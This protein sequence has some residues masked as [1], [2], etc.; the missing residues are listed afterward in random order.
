[1]A[2]LREEKLR[3]ISEAFTYPS[4]MTTGNI[5]GKIQPSKDKA[6]Q[7]SVMKVRANLPISP[8]DFYAALKQLAEAYRLVPSVTFLLD[9]RNVMVRN[10]SCPHTNASSHFKLQPSAFRINTTPQH[11]GKPN[12]QAKEDGER[13]A[14]KPPFLCFPNAAYKALPAQYS[15]SCTAWRTAAG[16]ALPGV[17]Q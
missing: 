5:N 6:R 8:D 16:S 12:T 3:T 7:C 4:T 15:G 1:M 17:P 9:L 11:T 14:F 10:L 2:Q 13:K